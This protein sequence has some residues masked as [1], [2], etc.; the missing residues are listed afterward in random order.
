MKK[1]SQG[2]FPNSSSLYSS[3]LKVFNSISLGIYLLDCSLGCM[4]QSLSNHKLHG[5]LLTLLEV[6]LLLEDLELYKQ[7]VPE[8]SSLLK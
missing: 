4:P 2:F 8:F 7:E 6:G 1:K 5:K 3:F